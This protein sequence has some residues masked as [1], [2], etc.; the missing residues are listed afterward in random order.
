MDSH[1]P[2]FYS[3]I[4]QLIPYFLIGYLCGA[5]PFGMV[6]GRVFCG[7]DPRK[8]GSCNV[9]A[10]NVAR[11]CGKKWGALTL[12]C[13][14]SK[15]LIPI[16]II[17]GFGPF[18]GQDALIVGA[19]GLGTICGHM[20]SF[21]LSFKGGK[22]VA[23]TVGVFL[24]IHPLALLIAAG[25]CVLVIW[26]TGFVSAGSLVLA[27]MLP[28]LLLAFGQNFS[29]SVAVCISALVIFAHRENIKRLLAGTEKPWS[30]T[31]QPK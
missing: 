17:T 26:R 7:V 28:F 12:L 14:A 27:T 24:A 20:F 18:A 31:K 6:F 23:T 15:G 29:A 10:T 19:L 30:T 16:V 22:G 2:D 25:A 3:I 1:S 11:L 5:V 9:G 21:F 13:D 8:A 4:M